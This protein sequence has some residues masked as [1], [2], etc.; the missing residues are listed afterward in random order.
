MLTARTGKVSQTSILMGMTASK[1]SRLL[2]GLEEEL[3]YPLF[4]KSKR[5][6][7]PTPRCQQLEASLDFYCFDYIR[8]A[9]NNKQVEFE[10]LPECTEQDVR[11]GRIDVAMLNHVPD[12]TSEFKIRQ[13][14]TTTTFPLATPEYLRRFGV[15]KKLDDLFLTSHKN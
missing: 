11:E 1:I 6:L 12:D 4:D 7:F 10:I 3:G 5:P 13:I 15:P 2:C 14:A 8:Y 9:E